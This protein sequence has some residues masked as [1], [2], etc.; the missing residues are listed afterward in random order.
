MKDLC[1][2]M[3]KKDCYRVRTDLNSCKDIVRS[4]KALDG[5]EAEEKLLAEVAVGAELSLYLPDSSKPSSKTVELITL[6]EVKVAVSLFTQSSC[7]MGQ[8]QQAGLVPSGESKKKIGRVYIT[9]PFCDMEEIEEQV[10]RK[11][12]EKEAEE[13][14]LNGIFN[15]MKPLLNEREVEEMQNIRLEK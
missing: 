1:K 6:Y 5:K 8:G 12:T 11:V 2:L 9:S 15:E 4:F 13:L 3:D 14:V 7:K 10:R